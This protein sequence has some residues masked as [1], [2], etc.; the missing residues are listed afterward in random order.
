[1][2]T[3]RV[4]CL[5]LLFSLVLIVPAFAKDEEPNDPNIGRN[6][7]TEKTV[8]YGKSETIGLSASVADKYTAKY[9]WYVDGKLDESVTSSSYN[10][11]NLTV[12]IH[13][14]YCTVYGWKTDVR[15]GETIKTASVSSKPCQITVQPAIHEEYPE[16]VS[17]QEGESHVLTF[18]VSVNDG[19]GLTYKWYVD[20]NEDTSSSGTSFDTSTLSV[21]SHAVYC[22]VQALNPNGTPGLKRNTKTCYVSV[23]PG[24]SGS[25]ANFKKTATFGETT[26]NDIAPSDWFYNYVREAFEMGLISGK[27]GGRFAP[28]E[29]FTVAEAVKI[30]SCIHSIYYPEKSLGNTSSASPW[31]VPY[32]N[33]ATQNGII[34]STD[35]AD[36]TKPCTR[37][38][39]AYIFSRCLPEIQLP[40]LRSVSGIPDCDKK[41]KYYDNILTLYEAGVVSGDKDHS[42]HPYAQIKRSEA[43]KIICTMV[44]ME[45]RDSAPF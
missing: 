21:G 26:F 28:N 19:T 30:A 35:F 11:K 45:L 41:T 20:G 23:S 2:I 4:C 9:N 5:V 39:M 32:L 8:D 3:K 6:L 40:S 38:Q 31:Y 1:M 29:P 13:R 37:A 24:D 10:T 34:E 14:V 18:T 15:N 42:F 16:S 17:V 7:P 33:Y 43:A 36:Y 44:L 27:G 22:Q 25:M 12:G